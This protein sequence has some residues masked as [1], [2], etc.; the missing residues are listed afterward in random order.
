M[1]TERLNA[2]HSFYIVICI[3]TFI[4][5]VLFFYFPIKSF[6]FDHQLVP[7]LPVEIIF[8]DQSTVRGFLFAN[9]IFLIFGVVGI[10][11]VTYVALS[12]VIAIM[13]YAPRVDILEIDFNDL[14]ELWSNTST[15][16][17]AY[18]HEA[19]NNIC[20]KFLDLKT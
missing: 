11:A 10:S 4:V 5:A 14:D 1:L 19:L 16:T 7:F 15:S 9:M 20:Q 12:F 18:R 17:C 8:V 13:S 3:A 2:N 6:I